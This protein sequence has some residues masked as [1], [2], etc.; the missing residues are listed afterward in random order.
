[1]RPLEVVVPS[2]QEGR[3]VESVL[4]SCLHLSGRQIIQC[5]YHGQITVDGAPCH[6]NRTVHAGERLCVL[7]PQDR[8]VWQ[9][10][11]ESALPLCL[12]YED[13]DLLVIDKQAPLPTMSSGRFHDDTLEDMVY[14]HLGCPERYVYR[15]VNR[16]DK[17]TSGLMVVALNAF[18]QEKLQRQLHTSFRFVVFR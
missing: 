16:L 2:Q 17:G 18:S 10:T 1:M 7:F 15:P 5:K 6:T 8:P 12:V 14:T 13:E 11:H 3:S 9:G 4:R